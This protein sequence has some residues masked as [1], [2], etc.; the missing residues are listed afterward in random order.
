MIAREFI[1][2]LHRAGAVKDARIY[3]QSLLFARGALSNWRIFCID[4]CTDADD[5]IRFITIHNYED[6]KIMLDIARPLYYTDIGVSHD[7]NKNPY[8]HISRGY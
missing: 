3:S 1:E 8:L 4:G 6:W 5:V 7:A 2:F